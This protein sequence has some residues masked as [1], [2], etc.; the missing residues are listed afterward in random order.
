MQTE[1]TRKFWDELHQQDYNR[2]WILPSSDQLLRLV[3]SHFPPKLEVTRV[4]EIGCGT[5]SLA[6]QLCDFW[7]RVRQEANLERPS[8]AAPAPQAHLDVV[9]TDISKVCVEQQRLRKLSRPLQWENATLEYRE[10]SITELHTN[11]ADSFDVILDKGCLD[12]CLFRSKNA[13]QWLGRVLCNLHSWLSPHGGV[14]SIITPRSKLKVL[15]DFEG[16]EVRRMV[17]RAS[18]FGHGSLV[19]RSGADHKE[20]SEHVY[21]HSCQYREMNCDSSSV[22]ATKV[23]FPTR[24]CRKCGLSFDQFCR[25]RK[26]NRMLDAKRRQ[27]QNHQNHCKEP[28][29]IYHTD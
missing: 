2:E 6:L 8:T 27:W 9:A 20:T 15:K 29:A 12:T 25:S 26:N 3:V 13:D 21:F 19:P 17:L 7:E 18:S 23:M 10:L 16:F 1:K 14:Y 22:D 4:L 5:S 24:N 11:L 28:D